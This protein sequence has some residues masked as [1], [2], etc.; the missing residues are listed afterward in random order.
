ML[1]NKTGATGI[2]KLYVRKFFFLKNHDRWH[3]AASQFSYHTYC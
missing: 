3:G 2:S 1:Q